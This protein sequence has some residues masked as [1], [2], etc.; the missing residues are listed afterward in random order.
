MSPPKITAAKLRRV[1]ACSDQVAT[2]KRLFPKG[3]SV[4]LA[5]ARKAAKAELDLG[6]FSDYFLSAPAWKAY[7]EAMAPARKAYAEA[8]ATALVAAW[9]RGRGAR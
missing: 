1:G 4:T 8:T 9:D 2:F 5:S 7:D 3:T 6:W